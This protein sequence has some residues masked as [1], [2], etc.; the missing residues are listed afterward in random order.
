MDPK[1]HRRFLEYLERC[2]YFR[3]ARRPRLDRD[4]WLALD[5]ERWPLEEK[6]AVEACT[7]AELKRL[8]LV[9]RALLID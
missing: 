9:R 5:L 2:E 3:A 6:D 1:A 8:K 7:A 4:E